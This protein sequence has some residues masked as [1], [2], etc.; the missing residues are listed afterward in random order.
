[1]DESALLKLGERRGRSVNAGDVSAVTF[2]AQREAGRSCQ[3]EERDGSR[4]R[5]GPHERATQQG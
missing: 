5:C 2:V 3:P 1:M 4:K